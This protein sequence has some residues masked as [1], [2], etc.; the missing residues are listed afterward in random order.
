MSHDPPPDEF[1]FAGLAPPGPPTELREKVLAL[2]R[3]ALAQEAVLDVWT[4]I[5]ES[6]P[7]RIAWTAAAALLV[8]A[9][10][11]L[12]VRR[13]S[14]GAVVSRPGAE[15]EREAAREFAALVALPPIDETVQPL[16]GR[17]AA[18]ASFPERRPAIR[19]G[20]QS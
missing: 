4:R 7:L 5:R 11:G 16:V 6:R 10:V 20:G 2:A 13:P 18:A 12:S 14:A 9:N 1:P 3:E 8:M 15:A 17:A 19:R